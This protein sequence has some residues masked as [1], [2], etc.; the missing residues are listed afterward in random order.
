MRIE[1]DEQMDMRKTSLLEL[2]GVDMSYSSAKEPTINKFE[3][4]LLLLLKDM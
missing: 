2:N 4:Y 1:E 3:K